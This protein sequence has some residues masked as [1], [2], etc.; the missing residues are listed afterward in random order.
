MYLHNCEL[1][2]ETANKAFF[3]SRIFDAYW[4]LFKKT[5]QKSHLSQRLL[6]PHN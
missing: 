4:L 1:I 2:V 6:R 5:V 3:I